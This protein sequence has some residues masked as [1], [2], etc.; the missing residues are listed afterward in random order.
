MADDYGEAIRAHYASRWSA[1]IDEARWTKGPV[2]ELPP[3]FGVLVIRRSKD[4]TAYATRGMS[5]PD[6]ANPIELH[7]LTRPTDR[8]VSELVELLTIVAHYH[9]TGQK[10]GLGHSVNFGRPWLDASLCT[11]GLI[12]LPYLDGPE[13]EWL[14][15]PKVRFLWL[16]PITQAE[17]A[18]K[19]ARGLDAL[20][21][22]F[23]K[24]KFNFLDPRRPS[25]V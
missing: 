21:E 13:L 23:E 7:L 3:T 24:R 12:S 15:Q 9:R 19:K 20:E 18:F 1:P 16:I 17:V 22:L 5:Q 6:D 2:H 25:V 10:L 11:H 8:T 4:M 14:E